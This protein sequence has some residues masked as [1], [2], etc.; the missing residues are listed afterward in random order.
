[1]VSDPCHRCAHVTEEVSHVTDE[2]SQMTLMTMTGIYF[3]EDPFKT[4][5]H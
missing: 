1:M 5:L 2:V 3:P 4:Q